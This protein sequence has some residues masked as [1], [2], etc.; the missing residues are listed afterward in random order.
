MKSNKS[1][2]KQIIK[3]IYLLPN[4]ITTASLYCGIMSIITSIKGGDLTK[5]A[6]YI[7]FAT[8]FDFLDGYVARASNTCSAFGMEYDSLSDVVS[9]GVAP[10]V[11]LFVGFLSDLKRLGAGAVFVFVACSALR[12][13]RFNS[14]IEGE[15]KVAFR[16]LPTTA[17]A[18]FTASLFLFS[19]KFNI[20]IKFFVPY[21]M[22]F[23]SLLMV[24]S[25]RY[26]AISSIQIWKKKPFVYMGMTIIIIGFIFFFK[27][28][29]IFVISS[30]Y[31]YFG[32]HKSVKRY[33]EKKHYAKI[34]GEQ[35][36]KLIKSDKKENI[37]NIS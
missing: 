20:S 19:H 8:I 32:L 26:P 33:F 25:I 14:K 2:K 12:L 21:L 22:L 29:S 23:I 9:F 27:E 11:L 7:L 35:K 16:G 3:G 13:A 17:S 36:L 31:I 1:K 6:Y 18:V 34:L 28:L 30:S 5:A 37:E 4:L 15:E 10:A 24:S